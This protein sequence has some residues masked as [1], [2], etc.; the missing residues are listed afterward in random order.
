[1]SDHIAEALEKAKSY[2]MCPNALV[3]EERGSTTVSQQSSLS[4]LLER[5]TAMNGK[6]MNELRVNLLILLAE[7]KSKKYQAIKTPPQA[8]IH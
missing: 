2:E 7:G 4:E 3:K 1:M 5:V 6:I 8:V